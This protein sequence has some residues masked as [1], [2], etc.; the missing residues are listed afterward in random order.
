VI[1]WSQTSNFQILCRVITSMSET[2][3]ESFEVEDFMIQIKLLV[4][5][6]ISIHVFCGFFGAVK[7]KGKVIPI[8]AWCGLEG[9]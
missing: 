7:G 6:E 9:G 2:T 8:Q 3:F 5:M 1:Y 4:H